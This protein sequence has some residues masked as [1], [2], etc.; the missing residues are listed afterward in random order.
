MDAHRGLVPGKRAEPGS[1][2]RLRRGHG[3][4]Q[5]PGREAL[6]RSRHA[7]AHRGPRHLA[8]GRRGSGAADAPGG[9]PR[10]AG[11]GRGGPAGGTL[12]VCGG[13]RVRGFPD[14]TALEALHR[15]Q[16]FYY[17]LGQL[18]DLGVPAQPAPRGPGARA[19]RQAGGVPDSAREAG[20]P[21]VPGGSR[22]SRSWPKR[23][24]CAGSS[25]RLTCRSNGFRSREPSDQH[26]GDEWPEEEVDGEEE[27]EEVPDAEVAPGRR[28]PAGWCDS[29]TRSPGFPNTPPL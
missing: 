28:R 9:G 7:Q 23:E 19:A 22:T 15:F 3:A 26:G 10:R 5:G 27:W 13:V 16:R 18:A 14:E 8:P 20:G 25:D 21:A 6:L 1:R 17:P 11:L 4:R 29:L 12:L 2:P 24:A